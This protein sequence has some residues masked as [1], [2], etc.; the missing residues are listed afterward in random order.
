MG[1]QEDGAVG[2]WSSRKGRPW[3]RHV[4]RGTRWR[5]GDN[6][7]SVRAKRQA[8]GEKSSAAC[9]CPFSSQRL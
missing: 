8:K 4:A 7:A 2:G 6:G 1:G 9:P 5:L 3:A